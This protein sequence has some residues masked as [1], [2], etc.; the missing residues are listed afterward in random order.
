MKIKAIST[1]QPVGAQRYRE[2]H[3]LYYDDFEVGDIYEHK[4]GRTITDAD[5]IWQSLI[6]SNNH[7]LHSDYH[8]A[9]TTEFGRPLISSL[10]TFSIIGG[11]SL[12]STSGSA[13]ANLGWKE[14]TLSN[15]VFVGDTLY[16]ES[17]VLSKR[18]S[19]SRAG[20]GVVTV[21]TR[22]LNQRGVEVLRWQRSFLVPAAG[23]GAP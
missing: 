15:P 17:T 9:S 7:P 4:P 21:M 19:R 20:Q 5:N 13:I 23:G 1:L 3:G 18:R 2:S 10:V 16:A 6:N 22:G 8:Y 11:L 12:A 14:V